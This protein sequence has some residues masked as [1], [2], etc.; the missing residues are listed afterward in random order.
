MTPTLIS[1][2]AK[3]Y[4]PVLLVG[5]LLVILAA[6]YLMGYR[7]GPGLSVVHTGTL[8]VTGLPDASILYVDQEKQSTSG[9]A[10]FARMNLVPGSHTIIVA[11]PNAIP[12]EELVAIHSNQDTSVSPVLVP[13]ELTQ[14]PVETDKAPLARAVLQGDWLPTP[15][16]WLKL[17]CV[18]IYVENNRVLARVASTTGETS[19]ASTS[20]KTPGCTPP[21]FLCESG[22]C[23]PT[24]VLAPR[25]TVHGVIPFPGR[26][27]TIIVAFG[28]SLIAIEIDPRN[29]QF[30]APLLH[31][32]TPY[33]IAPSDLS[34]ILVSAGGNPVYLSFPVASS[35][36]K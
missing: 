35:T 28:S 27:D 20:P 18:D 32:T 5:V 23:A 9:A 24:V 7:P 19:S 31:G 4:L 25:E 12:W 22:T 1:S 3:K 21:P 36:K 15:A 17:P 8:I 30:F 34:H 29:P 26:S 6:G 16:S 2:S 10:G 14:T 13:T 33:R 11:A